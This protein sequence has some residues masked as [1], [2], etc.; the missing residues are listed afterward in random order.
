E[1]GIVPLAISLTDI[2]HYLVEFSIL[3]SG[4]LED[5]Q[6]RPSAFGDIP[7]SWFEGMRLIRHLYGIGA[8]PENVNATSEDLTTS[9]FISKKAAMLLDGSWRA[10]GV[11]PENWDST[12]V[13]PFPVYSDKADETAIIGGTSMGFYISRRA[14]EDETKRDAAVSLLHHL[15]KEESKAKFGLNFGGKL[16]QSAL[17]LTRAAE[18]NAALAFPIGDKMNLEARNYWFDQIPA[19]ADGSADIAQ[20]LAQTIRRGAFDK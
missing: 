17:A 1:G 2:P 6:K 5:H 16:L 10:N 20:V 14:W 19:I 15:T 8:F 12:L 3:A 9:L 11:P 13:L 18:E 7:S 4:S